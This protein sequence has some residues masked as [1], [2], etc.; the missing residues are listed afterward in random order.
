MSAALAVARVAPTVAVKWTGVVMIERPDVSR[1]A[2]VP[3]SDGPMCR[4]RSARNAELGGRRAI[5]HQMPMRSVQ[6][7]FKSTDE[8]YVFVWAYL[9]GDHLELLER[10]CLADWAHTS[11]P[12]GVL[13]SGR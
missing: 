7:Y 13:D 1:M 11:S 10:A 2:H 12:R 4:V 8:D 3:F 9:A 5:V 6:H